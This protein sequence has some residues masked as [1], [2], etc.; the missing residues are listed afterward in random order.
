M[1]DGLARNLNNLPIVQAGGCGGYFKTGWTIN[2]DSNSAGSA[3]LTQGNSTSGCTDGTS[4]QEV[5]GGAQGTGT[6]ANVANEPINK[7][8][9]TLMNALGV[10]GGP[11]GFPRQRWSRAG[12]QGRLFRFDDGLLRRARRRLRCHNPQSRGV[13]GSQALSATRSLSPPRVACRGSCG[14]GGRRTRCSF[15]LVRGWPFA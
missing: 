11:D 3:T 4:G 15:G 7:Y 8:Y 5:N 1:S 9:Y 12:D 13:D 2:V 10:K 6:A 14:V